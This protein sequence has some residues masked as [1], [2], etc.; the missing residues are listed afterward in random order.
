VS[1]EARHIAYE[2]HPSVLD[3]LGL[4]VSLKA[5]CDEFAKTE[6]MR[7]RFTAGKLPH[8]IPQQV[9]SSLYRIAQESLQNVAK[10]A[11]AKHLFVAV[12]M[13]DHSLEL[14]LE[15]DGIG[16]APQAVKGKGGLGLVSMRERA[17]ILGASLSIDSK[18]G[19]GARI[20]IKVPVDRMT[21]Q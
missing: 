11:K 8:L 6:K 9:A 7:V 19:D 17:R 20:S 5:L 10:H 21:A 4:V 2:L 3:D 1:E 15:D 12:V 18:P 13:R 16:F 14:S